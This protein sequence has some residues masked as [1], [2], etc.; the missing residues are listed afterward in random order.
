MR[1]SSQYC[2][3]G[4]LTVGWNSCAYDT[5]FISFLVDSS[6]SPTVTLEPV[7]LRRITVSAQ[8]TSQLHCQRVWDMHLLA[9][10]GPVVQAHQLVR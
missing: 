9:L 5:C 10:S 7:P 2:R 6:N 8:L 3:L 1:S 4:L